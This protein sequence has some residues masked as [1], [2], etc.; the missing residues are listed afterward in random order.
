MNYT[1]IQFVKFTT[2]AILLS[3]G[4]LSFGKLEATSILPIAYEGKQI[5]IVDKLQLTLNA[6]P[7]M[8]VRLSL[9][10]TFPNFARDLDNALRQRG[11]LGSAPH[12]FYWRGNT[13]IHSADETIILR[14]RIAYE[15]WPDMGLGFGRFR[16]FGDVKYIDWELY[17]PSASP[18]NLRI[19]ARILNVIGLDNKLERWLGL[20]VTK[21][22]DIPIPLNCGACSC[23]E[24]EE[25]INPKFE[26]TEFSANHEKVTAEIAL[27]LGGD[28]SE[29]LSCLSP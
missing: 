11:N 29:V 24:I 21:H 9:T 14:S 25:A 10:A 27:V 2:S 16:L 17:I 12:R 8:Q 3:I 26:N 7:P 6:T 23:S 13:R 20:R 28:V 19:H 1:K 5:G 15:N 4:L 22:I 18:S